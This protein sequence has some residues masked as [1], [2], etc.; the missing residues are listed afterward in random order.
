MVCRGEK[1]SISEHVTKRKYYYSR[2]RKK[3]WF[4]SHPFGS[5]EIFHAIDIDVAQE[6]KTFDVI[7]VMMN[8]L[9][10]ERYG[11]KRSSSIT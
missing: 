7:L 10:Q 6:N 11:L 3:A 9:L 8:E 5:L 4:L 2:L 1:K